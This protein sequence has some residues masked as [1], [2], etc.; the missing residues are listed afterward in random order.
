MINYENK[1]FTLGELAELNNTTDILTEWQ[2]VTDFDLKNRPE[3][4]SNGR[5]NHITI[6]RLMAK[7]THNFFRTGG[8]GNSEPDMFHIPESIFDEYEEL[9]NFLSENKS[10][11]RKKYY[12]EKKRKCSELSQSILRV[13][14]K[15][16]RKGERF[17]WVAKSTYFGNNSGAQKLKAALPEMT[18]EQ[19]SREWIM[20]RNYN[21]DDYYCL[22]STSKWDGNLFETEIFMVKTESLID[23]LSYDHST[24][25]P[26]CYVDVEKVRSICTPLVSEEQAA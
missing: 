7:L 3:I 14:D 13:E 4:V 10:D 15:A 19:L 24:S 11:S 20:E 23:C 16:F 26:F 17:A 1:R 12:R 21:D 6:G 8:Q 2:T 22:T 9:Q 5:H 18:T 25:K